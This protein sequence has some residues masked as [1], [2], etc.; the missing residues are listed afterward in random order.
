MHGATMKI[1]K[2]IFTFPRTL[3]YQQIAYNFSL[4]L[5]YIQNALQRQATGMC[6]ALPCYTLINPSAPELFCFNFSTPCI[7]NV[8]NTDTKELSIMKQTAF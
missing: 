7:Y 6:E 8:N 5:H 2:H 4:H 1:E 3:W